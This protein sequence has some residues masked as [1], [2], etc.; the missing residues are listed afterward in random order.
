[1][2]WLVSLQTRN[3][4][5]T[6]LHGISDTAHNM[7]RILILGGT[8]EARR[9]A[10]RL[11]PRADLA[12]MLSLAGRT[13]S[14][15]AQPV[16]TRIGGFGGM[17]GLADYIRAERIE[18]V[19]DATHPYAAIISANAAGAAERTGVPIL[20]LHRA[21]WTPVAGDRWI[22]VSGTQAAVAAIG[23]APR[24]VFVTLG[25]KDLSAFIERPQ[26][27]YVVRSVDPV[28]PPLPVPHA[29]YVTARGPFTQEEE[30]ALM[31]QYRVE[32]IISRNSGGDASYGKIA[33]AR[34]LN[35][36]VIMLR[37]PTL[38]QVPAVERVEDV[39]AWFD[40]A[41]ASSTARGV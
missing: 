8:A 34:A 13:A 5:K 33:A 26:H 16:A 38:P 29:L 27:H 23:S 31:E 6:Q 19:I 21:P 7:R 24:R 15:L 1:L 37:R 40:H 14:P 17:Q 39:V 10:Q 32:I 9:L 12:I 35:L 18:A 4:Y 30:R 25:R 41:L 2:S 3:R 28:D 22:D 36:P 11:A 20:A